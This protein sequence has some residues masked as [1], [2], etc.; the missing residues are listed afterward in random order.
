MGRLFSLQGMNVVRRKCDGGSIVQWGQSPANRVSRQLAPECQT[1][2]AGDAYKETFKCARTGRERELDYV[3]YAEAANITAEF[4]I[5]DAG[6][7][8][9]CFNVFNFDGVLQYL[10]SSC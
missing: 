7:A 8:A 2:N 1:P 5:V 10:A 9:H 4:R 6:G 3:A